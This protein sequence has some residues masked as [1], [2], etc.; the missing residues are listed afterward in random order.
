MSLFN[1]N[2]GQQPEP[3]RTG[4]VRLDTLT[5]APKLH[6]IRML[7]V[8]AQRNKGTLCELPI[9]SALGMFVLSCQ[10]DHLST[11]PCWT[12]YEGEGTKQIWSYMNNDLD[13]IT[14]IVN[15]SVA[16][17]KTGGVDV[18]AAISEVT[19][20]LSHA[21]QEQ[22]AE[23]KPWGQYAG[24]NSSAN[25]SASGNS[26]PSIQPNVEPGAP[27]A[28]PLAEAQ[29]SPFAAQPAQPSPFA[30]QP[31]PF[32]AQPSPFAPQQA[33]PFAQP[34]PFAGPETQWPN[35]PSP[36]P[37]AMP[38]PSAMPAPEPSPWINKPAATQVGSGLMSMFLSLLD[39]RKNITIGEIL[40]EKDVP[41]ACAD[42]AMRLQEMICK[43]EISEPAAIEALK[44]AAQRGT[45]IVDESILGEVRQ[46]SSAAAGSSRAAAQLLKD[47]GLITENDFAT[48]LDQAQGKDIGEALTSSGKTDKLIFDAATK[49]VELVGDGKIRSDQAI[50]ALHYCVRARA[51]IEQAFD[52]LSI[53][54]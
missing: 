48:A 23:S 33:S 9:K 12:L 50:I 37:A 13:M 24:T 52:D 1:R 47:A 49:C 39:S 46:R 35:A 3:K 36:A 53:S 42:S 6:D 45:G 51:P 26:W 40:F 28:S 29:P 8:E 38:A 20:V 27:E 21:V 16:E 54:V 25:Q 30:G 41:P 22:Q 5:V 32:A 7:L 10:D 11:E 31:S 17:K 18:Q 15:M 2:Q 14:D 44:L 19:S 43:S 4:R 34:T